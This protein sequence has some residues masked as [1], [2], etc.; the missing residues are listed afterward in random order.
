[1][2]D[3]LLTVAGMCGYF[4]AGSIVYGWIQDYRENKAH[5]KRQKEYDELVKSLP[6]SEYSSIISWPLTF[7]KE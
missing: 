2:T 4:I 5:E 7:R 3:L 1:M 6:K